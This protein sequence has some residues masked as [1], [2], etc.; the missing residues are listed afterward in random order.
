MLNR[1]ARLRALALGATC[2][3]AFAPAA[4]A[5]DHTAPATAVPVQ[6]AQAMKMDAP[7]A[8]TVTVGGL[9]IAA[10]WARAT[11]GGAKVAGGF[12]RI[13][14]NG[15]ESDKLV[16]G[17]ADIAGVFEVHEMTMADGVMKMRPVA[18]G[19]EIKPGQT[20][21]LKPGGYHVMF[22]DIKAPFKEGEKVK[23]TLQF[24]KAGRV[25]V[26]FRVG[27]VGEGAGMQHKGH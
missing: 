11:P 6:I 16:G 10:P 15:K 3:A 14:N 24:E 2:A 22:M 17:S 27:G 7:V 9:T 8:D 4:F 25:E 23:A 21:E 19:L 1:N 18:G 5:H 13:T 12:V 20:I 26:L